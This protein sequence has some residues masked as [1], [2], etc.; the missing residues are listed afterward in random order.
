MTKLRL[1]GIT[2]KDPAEQIRQMA[3]YLRYLTETLNDLLD[4]IEQRVGG[5]G[6]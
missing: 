5:D 3:A 4:E 6:Q 2:A 1:P